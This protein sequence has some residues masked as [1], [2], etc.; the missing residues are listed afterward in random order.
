MSPIRLEVKDYI[1]VVT[2]DYPPVNAMAVDAYGHIIEIFDELHDRDDARVVVLTATGERAF[3]AGVD[4]RSRIPGAPA[5]RKDHGRTAREGLIAS[6]KAPFGL[7][8]IDVGLLGGA[9]HSFRLFPQG[10]V[11]RMHYT[12]ERLSAQEAYRLGAVHKVVP[13]DR[14]MDEAMSDAAVIAAK[15]PIGIRL[16]KEGLNTVEWMDLKN[17]YRFEQC[18][19]DYRL[20]MLLA[21][22]FWVQTAGAPSFPVSAHPLRDVAMERL[23]AALIDLDAGQLLH[24]L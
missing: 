1:A 21:F 9:R 3:C 18:L 20:A 11:R 10:V 17:G 5:P 19:R 7:P 2:I 22:G 13:P 16:A 24:E 8:E 23:S 12:A 15:M 6:G 4:V 14:L